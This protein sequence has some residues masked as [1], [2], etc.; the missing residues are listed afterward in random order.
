MTIAIRRL[1]TD[2]SAPFRALVALFTDVFEED[3]EPLSDA[4]VQGLLRDA[5]FV[6]FGAA[7]GTGGEEQV[8][9]GVTMRIWEAYYSESKH[10]YI[11]D[12]AV[13]ESHQR[14]GIATRLIEACKVHAK[15]RGLS[16]MWVQAEAED[17]H[18]VAFYR[19]L[20]AEELSVS[21][22]ELLG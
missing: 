16:A 15:E 5:N 8:V 20:G 17:E 10:G 11:Y 12:L 19:S 9:G 22:F 2:D 13:A 1:T 4:Y 7:D 21:H 14:Q 6:A 18:A 3:S